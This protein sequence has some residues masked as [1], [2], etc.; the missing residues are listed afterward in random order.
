MHHSS[1]NTS[2]GFLRA[3]GE[4]YQAF[5]RRDPS[6]LGCLRTLVGH[7]STKRQLDVHRSSPHRPT[8][9]A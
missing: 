8:R 6:R 7:R 5:M 9:V 4:Q 1:D 3:K 2:G